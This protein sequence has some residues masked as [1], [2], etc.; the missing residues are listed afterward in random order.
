MLEVRLAALMCLNTCEPYGDSA[1]AEP[2]ATY[3]GLSSSP[4]CPEGSAVRP[5]GLAIR[6][7]LQA[8]SLVRS[9]SLRKVMFFGRVE[10]Q[11]LAGFS[12]LSG[13]S[14]NSHSSGQL[15]VSA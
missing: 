9:T 14:I 11:Y 7:T 8:G 2:N 13:H 6:A 5:H 3:P 15:S 4:L 1:E 10:S 12:S